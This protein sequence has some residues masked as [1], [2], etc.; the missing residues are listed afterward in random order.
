MREQESRADAEV[1]RELVPPEQR[2][3]ED[4]QAANIWKR[5]LFAMS[6][7]TGLGFKG[8]KT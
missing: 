6:S 1:L 2:P 8:L 3:R 5:P 7:E 4:H